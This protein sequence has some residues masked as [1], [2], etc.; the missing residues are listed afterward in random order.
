MGLDAP[1]LLRPGQPCCTRIGGRN[2]SGG[3]A[4]ERQRVC[5]LF[6]KN[7]LRYPSGGRT[8]VRRASP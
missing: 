3:A 5:L 1:A 7:G 6:S 8:E 2:Y 4:R